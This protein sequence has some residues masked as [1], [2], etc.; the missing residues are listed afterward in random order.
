M[1]DTLEATLAPRITA[2]FTNTLTADGQSVASTVTADLNLLPIFQFTDGTTSGKADKILKISGRS[3]TS[4]NS[5]TIDMYDLASFDI[6]GGAG[7]DNLG[8]TVALADACVVM[9]VNRSTSTGDLVIGN[10]GTT[11][12]WNSPF[13]GS[14]TASTTINPDG[15]WLV[16]TRDDPGFVIADTTNHLLKLAASGG[17][18]VYDAII[19]GRSA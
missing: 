3:I 18:V 11:A 16:A 19:I 9:I 8:Q 4:G 17:T 10:D 7:K 6:G 13:S 12:A 1:A 14:D 5:E 2:T 15:I